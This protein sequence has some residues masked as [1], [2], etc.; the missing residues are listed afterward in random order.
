M[1]RIPSETKMNPHPAPADD[2]A[3]LA[4]VFH[5]GMAD[6][7]RLPIDQ[8]IRTLQ[9]LQDLVREIGKRVQLQNGV[10]EPDGDFGLQLLGGRT[11]L[12]LKR[13]SLRAEAVATRDVVNARKT[14]AQITGNI[15]GYTKKPIQSESFEDSLV[16]RRL[17]RI[18]DLQKDTKTQISI[19]LKGTGTPRIRATLGP[20]TWPNLKA[21][22]LPNMRVDG[23]TAYGKLR[24]INDRSKTDDR[25]D[26]FWGEL[27]GDGHEIWR[28]R[29]QADRLPAVLPLFGKQVRVEGEAV[30]FGYRHPRI[31]VRH[32]E[33]D[34]DRDYVAALHAMRT[35]AFKI[36]SEA[37]TEEL[38]AELHG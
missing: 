30:Y 4:V 20:K 24:Q 12:L 17:L 16:A 28:L 22:A 10:D 25:P 7:H 9:E 36:F 31:T 15:L 37:T 27:I 18:S 34:E 35:G 6:T 11:G 33:K 29:F 1:D 38:L 5:K 21:A 19:I 8:V 13:G 23:I 26:H 32:I 3:A 2:T 14:F